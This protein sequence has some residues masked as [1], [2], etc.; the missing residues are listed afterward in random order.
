M[1]FGD[2]VVVSYGDI[3]TT[4]TFI[5][6][7]VNLQAVVELDGTGETVTVPK[8]WLSTEAETVILEGSEQ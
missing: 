7:V 3:T 8:A 2:K 5:A 4:A 6:G 1:R